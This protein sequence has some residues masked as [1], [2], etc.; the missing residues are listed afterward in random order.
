MMSNMGASAATISAA[1]IGHASAIDSPATTNNR[2]ATIVTAAAIS[3]AILVVGIT[4]A[5]TIGSCDCCTN[6]RPTHDCATPNVS[7]SAVGCS[8][9]IA[10][11]VTASIT[12][13]HSSSSRTDLDDI[14]EFAVFNRVDDEGERSIFEGVWE[15]I[16]IFAVERFRDRHF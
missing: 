4:A 16:G 12:A 6:G 11:S 15:L 9:S 13:G 2:A 14:R 1:A 7:S 8:S 5:V 10:S 3:A